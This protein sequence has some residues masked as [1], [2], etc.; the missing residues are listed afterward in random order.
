M[1]RHR[2][3]AASSSSS[4]VRFVHHFFCPDCSRP[5]PP[6]PCVPPCLRFFSLSPSTVHVRPQ[7][8]RLSFTYL[9]N[10]VILRDSCCAG[11]MCS[12][13]AFF[14]MPLILWCHALCIASCAHVFPSMP[15][16][17]CLTMCPHFGEPHRKNLPGVFCCR[18][19]APNSKRSWRAIRMP[20][21]PGHEARTADCQAYLL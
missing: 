4:P 6:M 15:D 5:A 20:R 10:F 1:S 11:A 17:V 2:C 9:L 14:C 3:P 12:V 19:V 8:D 16:H 13:T 21:I 18:V 7:L